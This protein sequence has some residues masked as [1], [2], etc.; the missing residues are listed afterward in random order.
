VSFEQNSAFVNSMGIAHLNT[1]TA[2]SDTIDV[3]VS[4]PDYATELATVVTTSNG[5]NKVRLVLDR[6]HLFVSKRD[7]RYDVYKVRADG[8]DEQLVLAGTGNENS[9]LK[10]DTSPSGE[11]SVLVATRDKNITNKDGFVLSGLY[12]IDTKTGKHEKVDSSERIDLVGWVGENA[13]YVKIQAGASGQNPERHRLI[14]LDTKTGKT[15]QIAASNFFNDVLVADD[16]IFYAPSD[17]YKKD[18]KAFLFRSDANGNKIDTVFGRTVW[19]IVRTGIDEIMFDSDQVWYKGRV[20]QVFNSEADTKPT[21]MTSR[22]YTSNPSG[23][24]HARVDIRDGKGALLLDDGSSER[25][26]ASQGGLRNPLVWLSDTHLIYRV[27]TPTETADYVINA[28]GGDPV[29]IGD[30]S[31]APGA[32]RWYYFY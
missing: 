9:D 6:H 7:G 25:T 31:D 27:V 4:A 29:K 2:A 15:K 16:Y 22:L 12:N 8:S 32:D 5:L 24:S 28:D 19:T 17:A 14:S 21:S 1:P 30:V 20:S 11:K 23:D 10:F 13:V 26:L 18:P 3:S